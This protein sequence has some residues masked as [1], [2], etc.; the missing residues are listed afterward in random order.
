MAECGAPESVPQLQEFDS[1]LADV[2]SHFDASLVLKKTQRDILKCLW[3]GEHDIL[4]SLPTG[5]GLPQDQQ[6][7]E[8]EG[9]IQ[10]PPLP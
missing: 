10:T 3:E 8:E 9:V 2:I 7:E 6:E 1:A 5:Y 4:A